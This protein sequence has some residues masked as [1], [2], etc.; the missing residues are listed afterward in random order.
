VSELKPI[1]WTTLASRVMR[2]LLARKGLSYAE[3]AVELEKVGTHET[4]RSVEGKIQRG[5]LRASFFLQTLHAARAE[6]PMQWRGIVGARGT[7]EQRA[8]RLLQ[9][10][11]SARP[12][13]TVAE[14][15]RLLHA[16]GIDIPTP[17]LD[18]QIA[19]GTYPLTLLLQCA[20]VLSMAG[21]ER[22][23]DQTDLLAAA[24]E[25]APATR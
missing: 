4:A 14:L 17:A 1:T 24:A 23:V 5:A 16:I 21:L 8:S 2:G 15:G 3:L 11:M 19:T 7:W 13:M 22:F 25:A 10:E 6:Y 20:A 12:G 9:A 18:E